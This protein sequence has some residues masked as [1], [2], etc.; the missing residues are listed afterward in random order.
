MAER[1]LSLRNAQI[2]SLR[3]QSQGLDGSSSLPPPDL[4]DQHGFVRTLGGVDAYLALQA[5]HRNLH[6]DELDDCL[7]DGSLQVLPAVRGCIYLV[8]Q[9]D[10]AACLRIAY[11]LSAARNAR[12]LDKAG[13]SQQEVSEL[14]LTVLETLQ[15]H[16]CNV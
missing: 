13:V 10:R 7:V 1:A 12:D 9:Q 11:H 8:R 16:I 4:V 2:R 6:R 15:T 3:L 5:R 14:G